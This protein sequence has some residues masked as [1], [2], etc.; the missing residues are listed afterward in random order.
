MEGHG[1]KAE[2]VKK[3]EVTRKNGAYSGP[4]G[5]HR[6][7]RVHHWRR[8][9]DT[10]EPLEKR[11][12]ELWGGASKVVRKKQKRG[13]LEPASMRTTVRRGRVD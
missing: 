7:A 5:N 11:G 6:E 1:G 9:H 13:T 12:R 3:S 8:D 2:K 10:E 4:A